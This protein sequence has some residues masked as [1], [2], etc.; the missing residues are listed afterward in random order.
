MQR[1]KTWRNRSDLEWL[2]K[3]IRLSDTSSR[4]HYLLLLELV[5]MLQNMS[6]DAQ[7]KHSDHDW[8]A[9]VRVQSLTLHGCNRRVWRWPDCGMGMIW[10]S[11]GLESRC[12]GNACR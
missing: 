12:V 1:Q 8:S 10:G 2:E 11:A 9:D 6:T 5:G 3:D 7:G 4:G